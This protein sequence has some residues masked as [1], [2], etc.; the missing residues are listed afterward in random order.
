MTDN[1]DDALKEAMRQDSRRVV[2]ISDSDGNDIVL[3]GVGDG[4]SWREGWDNDEEL[5]KDVARALLNYVADVLAD[6]E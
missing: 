4:M 6:E 5:R 3:M 2:V 1:L